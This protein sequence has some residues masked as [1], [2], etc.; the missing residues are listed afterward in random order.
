MYSVKPGRGPSMMGAL[1]GVFAAIFGVIW[2]VGA[3]SMGA[4]CFFALFGVVFVVMALVSAV[5]SYHNATQK[6]RMSA[7]D[8]TTGDAEPDP[9]AEAL[10][11]GASRSR[12]KTQ[13]QTPRRYEGGFC[14]LCG[15]SAQPEFDYCPKCG[16]DI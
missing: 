13:T 6:N 8:I 10:G 14:P 1:G 7:F 5:Y 11:H 3:L 9:I 2:T 12:E 16:K 15:A 4:P